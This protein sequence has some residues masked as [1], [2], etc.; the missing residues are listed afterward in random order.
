MDFIIKIR[1]ALKEQG[2]KL[3]YIEN[4]LPINHSTLNRR[5][6]GVGSFTPEQEQQIK[7]L[8]QI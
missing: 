5:M 8:L 2:R 3:L 7:K 1:L 4:N 6:K